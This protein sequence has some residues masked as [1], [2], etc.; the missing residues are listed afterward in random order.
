MTPYEPYYGP[1]TK[2]EILK[3]ID[4]QLNT[5]EGI[6]FIDYQRVLSS[7]IGPEK[8]PG[9][10][11]NDVST[12]KERLLKDLSRNIFGCSL[13]CWVMAAKDED[14]ATKMNAFVVIV[15]GKIMKDPTRGKKAYDTVIESIST[16]G[17]SR[18]PQGMTILNTAI[19]FYSED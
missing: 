2:E 17:G 3:D 10:F 15:K 14:L 11:I 5:I 4:T 13:V 7:G 18:W 6:K 9:A 19:V 16:D 1:G 8:Y 12:D